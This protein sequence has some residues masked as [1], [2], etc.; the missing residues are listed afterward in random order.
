[1]SANQSGVA[2]P[3]WLARRDKANGSWTVKN[4]PAERGQAWTNQKERVMRVPFGGD[5]TNRVIRA[6]EMAHARVTPELAILGVERGISEGSIR[7]AEEFRVNQLVR[8]A[9]FDTNLLIDGSEKMSGERLAEMVNYEGLVHSIATMAGTEGAKAFLRGVKS[10]NPDLAKAIRE[11][12]KAVIKTWTKTARKKGDKWTA[13]SWGDTQP[14]GENGYTSGYLNY[15]IP[16]ATMLDMAISALEEGEVSS[17]EGEG[18]S[19]DTKPDIELIKDAVN[20]RTGRWGKLVFDVNVRPTRSVRGALGKRRSATNMGR[21]PRRIGRMLTDPQRRVF[22]KTTRGIGGIVII[23]QS[24]SMSLSVE[25]IESIMEA[26]PGC[27]IIGYS[28]RAGS[29]DVPNIWILAEGGKR[30]EQVR[31]GAGGNGVDVPAVK[32]AL[33]KA[34]RGESVIWV[35]DGIVTSGDNDTTYRNLDEEAARLVKRN[36]IHMVRNVDGAIESLTRLARGEHLPTKF[37]GPVHHAASRLE[38]L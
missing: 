7:S 37:I 10:V 34:R 19:E 9:G 6:H 24:G 18:E 20:G 3:E 17:G 16:L 22:D 35:C 5:E 23:D 4:G 29:V 15:V 30:V 2:M 12:E 21:N 32:F 33:S 38:F 27:T 8:T 11:V 13:K 14:V 1:M 26:S 31:R 25:D 36:G 28:H